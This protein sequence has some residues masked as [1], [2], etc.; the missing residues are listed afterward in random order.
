M[1][2]VQQLKKRPQSSSMQMRYI[3]VNGILIVAASKSCKN[4]LH[5]RVFL[6]SS[7]LHPVSSGLLSPT[8]IPSLSDEVRKVRKILLNL[9][10][11][12]WN[13]AFNAQGSSNYSS[14][15]G[16]RGS[17][18]D[19]TQFTTNNK[20]CISDFHPSFPPPSLLPTLGRLMYFFAGF[21]L[22]M[23]PNFGR[24]SRC[25]SAVFCSWLYRKL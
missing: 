22:G 5:S 21:F 11:K 12:S 25:S 7:C 15:T 9:S 18:Q 24:N 2:D 3:F 4:K 23:S 20:W 1:H 8:S 16:K 17:E 19:K 10:M 6:K 13:S 14:C